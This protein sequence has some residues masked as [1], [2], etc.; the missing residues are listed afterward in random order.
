MEKLSL[1]R[2]KLKQKG[3]LKATELKNKLTEDSDKTKM[4]KRYGDALAQVISSQPEENTALLAYFRG[5]ET[6]FANLSVSVK[7]QARL[8]FKYLTPRARA[9]CSRLDSTK[10]DSYKEVKDA[11]M[12]EYGLT[13]KTFLTRFNNFRKGTHDTFI[14]FASKL[15]GLLRQYLEVRKAKDFE[16]LVSLLISDR[17][18]SSLSDQFLRY[19]LSVENN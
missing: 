9:L 3:E 8:I 17:I 1:E 4:L 7:Y 6:Q 11:V 5:M 13:A 14:L 10:R 2:K 16:T 15:E 12:K 18:K 19:V